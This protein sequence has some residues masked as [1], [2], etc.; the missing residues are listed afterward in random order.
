MP[1]KRTALLLTI[2]LLTVGCGRATSTAGDCPPSSPPAAADQ[3]TSRP[4]TDDPSAVASYWTDERMHSAKPAPMPSK[5]EPKC[6][7]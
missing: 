1:T 3:A 2:L 4:V 5:P 6:G 7:H